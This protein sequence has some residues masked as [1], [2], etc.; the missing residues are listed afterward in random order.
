M[1]VN[2][3]S[4]KKTTP[5]ACHHVSTYSVWKRYT[6]R[7]KNCACQQILPNIAGQ[8]SDYCPWQRI[9]HHSFT[10]RIACCLTIFVHTFSKKH[11]AYTYIWGTGSWSTDGNSILVALLEKLHVSLNLAPLFLDML[12]GNRYC[13]AVFE[14]A[15]AASAFHSTIRKQDKW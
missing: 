11:F 2:A 14:I 12:C 6:C 1:H 10:Q 8:C 7:F 4:V 5:C 13:I 3:F 15:M 9:S